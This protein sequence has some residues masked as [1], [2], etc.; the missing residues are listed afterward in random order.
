MHIRTAL[1][2]AAIL[3]ALPAS[4]RAADLYVNPGAAACSDSGSATRA[5]SSATPWCSPAPALKLARAGDVVHLASATYA[6]Q[7]RPLVSGTPL[8][9]IV[10]EAGGPVTITAPAG[11]VPVMLT[12]VHDVVL[13]G[14]TVHAAA[15]QGVWIDNSA[16]VLIDHASVTNTAGVGIQINRG[17]GVTVTRSRL[18]GNS[19][20]GLLD[21]AAARGT[22]LSAST[23]VGNGIDGQR[24]NGDGVELDD[25]G[26]TVTGNTINHNGDGIGFEHGI[27]VGASASHYTI[28]GNVIA[29][30][31]GADIKAEG[32]P[33]LVARN[34]LLSSLF[35]LVLS[36]NPALVTIEYNLIQGRF[37][38]GVLLTTGKTAARARLWNNTVE[39]TGRSTSS[40]NA[41]AIFVASATVLDLRNNL[42]SY[43]NPD[44]LGSALLINDQHLLGHFASSTNWFSSPDAG[45]R[46]VAWD[47]ARVTFASW[48]DLTG[49]DATSIDSQPPAFSAS[50]RVLPPN[51]GAGKGTRLGL[52]HDLAGTPLPA[53]APPD[54]GAFQQHQ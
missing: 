8:Q 45:Q 38:H 19:R 39:Q 29:A 47:G 50:G 5:S 12:G 36:D 35:G 21:M 17:I 30:N 10:F 7:L 25:T 31:A 1:P 18:T 51:L 9:P 34:R 14:L 54:I 3:C 23:V 26:A 13:R 32:G 24:Y 46:R 42:I 20:A 43:T 49:Q 48:R 27:Y 44:A 2:L 53:S 4:A 6:A 33:G 52:G 28:S 37:Q 40:G 41:S 22:T 16:R 15:L 11:I